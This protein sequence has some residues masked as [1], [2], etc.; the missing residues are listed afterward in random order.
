[1]T[2]GYLRTNWRSTEQILNT[3]ALL[4]NGEW[5]LTSA[6]GGSAA[7]VGGAGTNRAW[8]LIFFSMSSTKAAG[9]FAV[10]AYSILGQ[11]FGSGFTGMVGNTGS[12]YKILPIQIMQR[13][14]VV[15]NSQGN[16]YFS[17]SNSDT[18]DIYFY[19]R[20]GSISDVSFSFSMKF[21]G[22][23]VSTP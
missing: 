16:M 7:S 6:F 3:D 8:P 17:I 18:S 20:D 21:A 11:F 12:G 9:G 22:F 13:M 10:G 2:G 19:C 1:M 5:K 15:S 23:I 4:G 14:L